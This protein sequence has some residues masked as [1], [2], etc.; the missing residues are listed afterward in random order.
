MLVFKGLIVN[1]LMQ[2]N[3]VF[4]NFV[5][6]L[7]PPPLHTHTGFLYSDNVRVGISKLH[8]KTRKKIFN[9]SFLY[10]KKLSQKF[11]SWFWKVPSEIPCKFEVWQVF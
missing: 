9:I 8:S 6:F 2:I 1:A 11:A 7:T 10:I 3:L 4:Y 5:S